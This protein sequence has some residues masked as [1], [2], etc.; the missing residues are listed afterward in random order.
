MG[1]LS[2]RALIGIPANASPVEA[3][4]LPARSEA[5]SAASVAPGATKAQAAAMAT[6][7]NAVPMVRWGFIVA[8]FLRWAGRGPSLRLLPFEKT[9]IRLSGS[10]D[11][12]AATSTR[13]FQRGGCGRV[14]A[15]GAVDEMH[16]VAFGGRGCEAGHQRRVLAVKP[17]ADGSGGRRGG[18]AG[19]D[20]VGK[21]GRAIEDH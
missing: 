16:V 1:P 5:P 6:A 9:M 12:T 2:R 8:T 13:R 19:F 21:L 18:K 14:T 3:T 4:T 7:A 10:G 17:I 20:L 15:L 11:Q